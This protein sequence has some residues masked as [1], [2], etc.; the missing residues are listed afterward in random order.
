MR[1]HPLDPATPPPGARLDRPDHRRRDLA[2]PASD[3]LYIRD[4]DT[5]PPAVAICP[6]RQSRLRPAAGAVDRARRRAASLVF[7]LR[8][9]GCDDLVPQPAGGRHLVAPLCSCITACGLDHGLCPVTVTS[10][11]TSADMSSLRRD[12]RRGPPGAP[13]GVD[14]DPGQP[15]MVDHRHRRRRRHRPPRRRAAPVDSTIEPGADPAHE[16][17]ADIRHAFGDKIPERAQRCVAGTLPPRATTS[18]GSAWWPPAAAAG[19]SFGSLEAYLLLRGMRT[20]YLRVRA[21]LS[22][23]AARRRGDG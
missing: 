21:R 19:R 7:G 1:N 22:H 14:R 5:R 16:L 4:P 2:D 20:L 17:G 6:G 15:I 8:H 18:S 23:G 13:A 9:G 12:R 11:R 3:D 10:R